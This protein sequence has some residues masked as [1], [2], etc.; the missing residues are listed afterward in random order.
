[1]FSCGSC[2]QRKKY[3]EIE[4]DEYRIRFLKNPIVELPHIDEVVKQETRQKVISV[5][6]NS[7]CK[8]RNNKAL[9]LSLGQKE[10][11][12]EAIDSI[13]RK[14]DVILFL[15]QIERH[16]DDII[17]HSFNVAILSIITALG[18]NLFCKEDLKTIFLG[19]LLHDVGKIAMTSQ[20]TTSKEVRIL[21]E[22]E[23]PAEHA[24]IARV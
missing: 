17:A 14:R 15:S 23:L 16:S 18:M 11:V 5:V 22:E 12:F 4:S 1:M 24:I 8:L 21:Q 10:L 9:E 3:R 6:K 19:A 2:S 20:S 13:I 7:I